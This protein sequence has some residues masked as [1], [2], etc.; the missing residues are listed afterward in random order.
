MSVVPLLLFTVLFA[1]KEKQV[2]SGSD[3]GGDADGDGLSDS[4][5]GFW[6]SDPD[7]VDSDG[8][9]LE[10]GPEVHEYGTDPI[11]AD[12]DGDGYLDGE[13]VFDR[14]FD[15]SI[16]PTRF[17]PLLADIPQLEFTLAEPLQIVLYATE[18][19]GTSTTFDITTG[20]SEMSEVSTSTSNA[21]SS[22]VEASSTWDVRAST[23]FEGLSLSGSVEGGYGET[24]TTTSEQTFS[25]SSAQAQALES[26]YEQTVSSSQES[27]WELTGGF[28]YAAFNVTNVGHVGFTVEGFQVI[29]L[30]DPP[31]RGDFVSITTLSADTAEVEFPVFDLAGGQTQLL[32]L[33][34][35]ID[36]GT[37]KALLSDSSGLLV[38]PGPHR[39]LNAN[40]DS[41]VE[42]F[43]QI[44]GRTATVAID[45]GEDRGGPRR[46]RVATN[47]ERDANGEKSGLT[48]DRL[49]SQY[50]PFSYSTAEVDA[51]DPDSGELLGSYMHLSA[52]D[53]VEMESDLSGYWVVRTTAD[54]VAGLDYFS[55]DDVVLRAGDLLSL[56]YVSDG[57]LDGLGVRE[58]TLRGTDPDNA[59]SDGDGLLDGEEVI[60]GWTSFGETVYSD[61]SREDADDDL[62]A[63]ADERGFGLDPLSA[64]TDGDGVGDVI[65]RGSPQ[66]LDFGRYASCALSETGRILCSGSGDLVL[67]AQIVSDAPEGEGWSAVAVGEGHACAIASDGTVSCWGVYGE[68]MAIPS[69]PYVALD[70]AADLVC[71]LSDVGSIS[72]WA[73]TDSSEYVPAPSG[74]GFF[75]LATTESAVC[76]L[77]EEGAI[78]CWGAYGTEQILTD[79][80]AGSGYRQISSGSVAACALAAD[81]EVSCWGQD[82]TEWFPLVDLVGM[83]SIATLEYGVCGL[84]LSGNIRCA[85]LDNDGSVLGA[86]TSSGWTDLVA[87]M[88]VA[89]A[90]AGDGSLRTWGRG[91]SMTASLAE[92]TFGHHREQLALSAQS[93]CSAL[94]DPS[95]CWGSLSGLEVPE[96]SVPVLSVSDDAVELGCIVDPDDGIVC[97]GDDDGVGVI[98][99]APTTGR[100]LDVA[101]NYHAAC[102]VSA[103]G[104]IECWGSPSSDLVVDHPI[105][106]GFSSIEVVVDMGCALTT[107]GTIDCWGSN[108]SLGVP[109]AGSF[110]QISIGSYSA[111]AVAE[112]GGVSC[113]GADAE[114]LNGRPAVACTDVAVGNLDGACAIDSLGDIRCW[115]GVLEPDTSTAPPPFAEIDAGDNHFCA[116]NAHGQHLCWGSDGAMVTMTP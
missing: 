35:D 13:E 94:L 61:P 11:V 66:A 17:N 36:L 92:L 70:S 109:P 18:S 34:N 29:V 60:V 91:L 10:D 20:V 45:F 2:D 12:T 75:S 81:G 111:C 43:E 86:P 8:D 7:E 41:F 108:E 23:G 44:D 31:P 40:G 16:D 112:D 106:D 82:R 1:C 15:P 67:A 115:D 42:V 37:T 24:Y 113:W 63:D 48:I 21:Y 87:G 68:G 85:G 84:D 58:E 9:G 65:D 79:I 107:S 50:L 77:D 22:G 88:Y 49:F 110:T 102:A 96:G 14:D 53:G 100:W 51:Y 90:L 105:T 27:G 6:G 54:S 55:V 78:S 3:I 89:A 72:C 71:A 93:S 47:V 116:Y 4:D 64:D 32:A 104:T 59:D 19:G 56:V 101:V 57:D 39:L 30:D 99:D 38:Q 97:F 25:N 69:G 114:V 26:S 76:A 103:E 52:L 74:S 73:S 33:T 5:E 83:E 62:L 98:D 95:S 46:F 28:V 80:P